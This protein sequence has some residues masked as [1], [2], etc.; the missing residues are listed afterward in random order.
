MG[1]HNGWLKGQA[2]NLEYFASE[3]QIYCPKDFKHQFEN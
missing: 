3:W 1:G 2:V